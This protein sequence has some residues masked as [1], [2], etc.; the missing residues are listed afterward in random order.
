MKL[1]FGLRPQCE[2]PAINIDAVEEH[3]MQ[4]D[5][6]VA[7]C[8]HDEYLGYYKKWR[9][10]QAN[11]F[12]TVQSVSDAEQEKKGHPRRRADSMFLFPFVLD[13]QDHV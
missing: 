13:G 10:K 7:D 12:L 9:K 6:L 1:R 3:A 11:N 2:E 8:F 5:A 4:F